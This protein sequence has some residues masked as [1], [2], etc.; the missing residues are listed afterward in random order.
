MTNFTNTILTEE[1]MLLL[2]KG[3][4]YN[5]HYKPKTWIKRLALEAEMAIN[6]IDKN[7]QNF[8]RQIVANQIKKLINKNKQTDKNQLIQKK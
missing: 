8:M 7:Q 3:L 1:E 4:K 2:N 6:T 5:L